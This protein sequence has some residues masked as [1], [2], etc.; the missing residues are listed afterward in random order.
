MALEGTEV[1][2]VTMVSIQR[3]ESTTE[4]IMEI[5]TRVMIM[6][7]SMESIIWETTTET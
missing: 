2:E 5:T 3:E 6:A 1:T 4:T 7:I